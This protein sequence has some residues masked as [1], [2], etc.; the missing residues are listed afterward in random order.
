MNINY[1]NDNRYQV[2]AAAAVLIAQ[3]L[4][5][6]QQINDDDDDNVLFLNYLIGL[7]EDRVAVASFHE[8]VVSQ[9]TDDGNY[10][11]LIKSMLRLRIYRVL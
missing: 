6:D 11:V 1:D 3:F 10:Y 5:L 2:A 7:R 4:E 8:N 9:M